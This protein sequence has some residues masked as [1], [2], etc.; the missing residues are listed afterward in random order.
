MDTNVLVSSLTYPY[1][2]L[3]WMKGAWQTDLILPLRSYATT[4]ELVRILSYARFG[5]SEDEQQVLLNDYLP[6][7]EEIEVPASTPVPQ[8]RDPNDRPFLELALAGNAD[9]LVTGDSDLLVLANEF[10]VPIITPRELKELLVD[11]T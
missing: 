3:A 7:C 9:A 10:P 11:G 4:A 6:W 1:G 8:P 2:S 5:L